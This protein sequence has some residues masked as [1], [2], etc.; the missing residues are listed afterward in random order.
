M[1]HGPFIDYLPSQLPKEIHGHVSLAIQ[2]GGLRVI[3]WYIITINQV[4]YHK[5]NLYKQN[6]S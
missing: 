6:L 1:E 5:Q 3:T 4:I 2:G